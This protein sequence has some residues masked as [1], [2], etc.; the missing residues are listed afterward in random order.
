MHIEPRNDL[1]GILMRYVERLT[2]GSYYESIDPALKL[3]GLTT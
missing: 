2:P 1:V 3:D